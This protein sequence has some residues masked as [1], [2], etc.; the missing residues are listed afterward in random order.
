ME[1]SVVIPIYNKINYLDRLWQCFRDQTFRDFQCILVDDGSS[2]GSAEACDAICAEDSRFQVFHIE[3][4]GVSNARN[5]GISHAEGKYLTFVDGDDEIAPS[6]LENLHRCIEEHQADLV[7]SGY[8]RFWENGKTRVCAHP[9]AA[10]LYRLSAL[11]PDFCRIQKQM[12][13]YG[14]C[15]AKIFPRKLAEGLKFDRNI[16]LAEDLDFYLRLYPRVKTVYLDDHPDYRY[17]QEAENCSVEMDDSKIDYMAQLRIQLRYRD[18][19]KS[20]SV[21]TGENRE[22][23]ETKINNYLYYSVFYCDFSGLKERIGQLREICT[24]N[25]L[26]PRGQGA[27]QK[28]MLFALIHNQKWV[29]RGF[30]ASYRSMR[31][32]RNRLRG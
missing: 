5:V 25:Q 20:Q 9:D 26:N 29:I 32:L 30:L 22:I 6:Y 4:G 8:T 21:Y 16:R 31:S 28:L 10:G 12:G 7:I 24:Q 14:Y 18:F 15:W 1:I 27:R 19:L 2:D 23:L 11:L 3:N 13:I 17:R